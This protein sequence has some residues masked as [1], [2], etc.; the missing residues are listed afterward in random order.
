MLYDIPAPAKLNLF[1][2]VVG[3]RA[4]G[5][6]LLQTVFQLI[7]LA[8]SLDIDVR[9]DGNICRETNLEGVA[10]DDD[11]VVRAARVLQ[12]A[13]GA[14]L[15]A[16]IHVRKQIPSGAGLGGGSSDAASVLIALNRL[17]GTGLSRAALMRLGLKLGADVPVFIFGQNAFA[18]GVGEQLSP[19]ELPARAYLVVQPSQ[20]VP[21]QGIFQAP[22]LTR[23]TEPVKIMDFSGRQMISHLGFGHNDLQPVVLS[24][25][26]VVRQT[27][28]WLEQA[29]FNARMTGSGSCFFIGFQDLKQADVAY[30]ELLAKIRTDFSDT[31]SAGPVSPVQAMMACEGLAE[32]P[33][34]YWIES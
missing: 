7:S 23:D 18:E 31:A 3:R 21:T 10:H 6:H 24:R 1:L 13:T 26:P 4:D 8:D 5:Y 19:I 29:G 25:Y 17:W 33:L 28:D 27:L 14:R 2:H 20:G 34:R 9:Q 32:H 11:L 16:Q 22:D 15:G 30:Q 12:Q